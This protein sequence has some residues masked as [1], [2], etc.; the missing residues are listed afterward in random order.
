[1]GSWIAIGAAAAIGASAGIEL[2]APDPPNLSSVDGGVTVVSKPPTDGTNSFYVGNRAPLEPS[3]LIKLPIGAIEP[4]GWLREQLVL[5]RDGMT[6]HMAELSHWVKPEGSAWLSKDGKGENGW[7]ELPYWLKGYGDLGY[8]LKDETT[9]AQAKRWLEGVMAAQREDGYFGSEDNRRGGPENMQLGAAGKLSGPDLWPH[10]PMI[11]ALKSYHEAKADNRVLE[12]LTRYFKWQAS[13]PKEQLLPAS[14]QKLRGGDNL[15]S[16]LWLYN[17][18]GETWLL[19]L[20]RTL[21]ERT[22]PWSEKIASWH[23]VNICQ[24]F[25]EPAVFWQVSKDKKDLDAAERNYQE[26]MGL[27]G[28]VPG[29]MFGADENCRKGFG[30][31]RQAAETCS[32]VEFMNSFEQLLRFTGD[33]LYADRCEE[34]AFN[35]LPAAFT[36][37]YKALHYLTAPNMVQLDKESKAPG[38]AN[39][40]TMISYDPG[41]VYRCCQHNHAMGWPYYAEHLWMATADNGLAAVLYSACEVKAR[42]GDGAGVTLIEETGYPFDEAVHIT[43]RTAKPVKFPLYLRAPA[44]SGSA[45]TT[46]ADPEGRTLAEGGFVPKEAFKYGAYNRVE[47][48]WRNGETVTMRLPMQLQ[49]RTWDSNKGAASIKRGPLW[50]S[51]SIGER[52]AAYKGDSPWPGTEVFPT[53][54]WNYGLV[55]D[56][57][58]PSA[59]FKFVK[60]A[61]GPLSQPF[62]ANTTPIAIKASARRIPAWQQDRQGLVAVLQ[63]S[64]VRSNEPEETVTLIPM[65]AA[66]LRITAFP[67]IGSGPDAHDWVAPPPSRHAASFEHDDID[68]VSDG[69][70]PKNSG[71]QSIPRFTWWDH[72]GT[73]EWIT[74]SFDKPRRIGGCSVYWFDDTGVGLCRVPASWKVQYKHGETWRDVRG[75]PAYGVETNTFNTARFEPV[76]TAALRIQVQL[77][78]TSSG[79]ILEWKV[80]DAR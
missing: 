15:E 68:A 80:A 2:P 43:V 5:M 53:T 41:E 39:S 6:G 29:G 45:I 42:V 62:T 70:E 51:L 56:R 19:D 35:S 60:A 54:R 40:G 46:V 25:R 57:A 8:M 38:L 69:K 24:G 66:R 21:H 4:K 49:I 61:R 48:V 17:R 52:S 22:S 34:V 12:F 18:T 31:P 3:P 30:D 76:S 78:D 59:S 58:D 50:Y 37:D 64:P 14:W 63:Q 77:R 79:G 74:Y 10:M 23:G 47:R 9:I 73:N 72:R 26:V 75:D 27:Y 11:D 28:Q 1:M 32:M 71:D 36:P 44:W 7:E 65:G 16:V 33:G 20:A 13:L 67:V 55:L